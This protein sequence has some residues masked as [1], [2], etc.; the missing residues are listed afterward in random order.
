[1]LK[2]SLLAVSLGVCSLF[3][4]VATA[5]TAPPGVNPNLWD[6]LG[7]CFA[8]P[9]NSTSAVEA[10]YAKAC[11]EYLLADSWCFINAGPDP[12]DIFRCRVN[13]TNQYSEE[14]ET[15]DS[16]IIGMNSIVFDLAT[17]SPNILKDYT[18]WFT[19]GKNQ[20]N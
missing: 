6:L 14:L 17:V 7:Y 8:P 20:S 19:A 4:G 13:A 12:R 5:Q 2:R 1:M 9:S 10:C 11:D 18:L 15:C 3:S 16:I